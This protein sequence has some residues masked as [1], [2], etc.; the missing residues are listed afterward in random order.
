MWADTETDVDFLNYGEVAELVAE[1][2]SNSQLLPLSV[3][4]FGTWGT[5][6]STLLRLV[7]GEL[8]LQP[9]K[10]LIVRFDAWLY[11]DFDDARAALMSVIAAALEEAA[12]PNLKKKASGLFQRINK[13]R[14][15]GLAVEGGAALFGLPTF[16]A[17]SRA[18]EALGDVV[19]GKADKKD[20]DALKEAGSEIKQKSHGLLQ[21][22][23]DKGPPQQVEDFRQE[24]GEVLAGTGKTLVVFIDN[25]DRCLPD[26]AIHTL[27][28]I[29]LF[30]FMPASAFVIAADE[31]M[32]RH[33]VARHFKDPGERHITDY[34]DKLIQMPV[35]VPRAGVQEVRAY[36]FLLL[37]SNSL[38]DPDAEERLRAY[39]I[40]RLQQSWKQQEGV[41]VEEVLKVVGHEHDATLLN[42]L[43]MANRMAPMLAHAV[44]VS[45]NPRI[46]KRLLNVVR[47][48]SSIAQKRGMPLDEALIAKLALFE[49]CTDSEATEALHNAIN[50]AGDGKPELLRE[51]ESA[52]SPGEL[53][54]VLPEQWQKHLPV[55]SDWV[56]L[57]PR[58]GGVDLRPAVY[59]ARE[60]VPLRLNE[61]VTSPQAAKVL[62][63]LL[64]TGTVGSKAAKEAIESL[65]QSEQL[66]VMDQ[67]INVMRTNPDWSKARPD[68]RGAVIVAR[69]SQSCGK[70]LKRFIDSL[71]KRA[72]WMNML[73]KDDP[74]QKG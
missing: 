11:Q 28:A 33:A 36:L 45:G 16:G 19:A 50:A 57:Q 32:I 69:A 14:M 25:L 51:L 4:I 10:Y 59:L 1:L 53:K 39:L 12:P 5:G 30:L 2:I 23:Q 24:F 73:I 56:Q 34:L 8:K 37:A 62:G 74:W 58:L 7:E 18:I 47:M 70:A 22:T 38:G 48:R 66:L 31:D 21:A 67:L 71:P 43:T 13:L 61:A 17:S 9:E 55:I 26:N 44:R 29:R 64:E 54:A 40:D 41:T 20:V 65:D 6:K 42:M 60:T 52:S 3:G 49:R 27:E 35:R 68:F 15:L 63:I 72:G 46:V